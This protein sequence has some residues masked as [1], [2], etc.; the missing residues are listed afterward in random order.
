MKM[1]M[2]SIIGLIAIMAFSLTSCGE[3]PIDLSRGLGVVPIV[4]DINPAVFDGLNKT[5]TFIK[6]TVDM[7]EGAGVNAAAVVVSFN[8]DQARAEVAN[9]TSFPTDITIT[10][11]D[12]ATGLGKTLD[13]ID[14]GDVINV[15]LV[16][17]KGGKTFYSEASFNAAVVCAYNPVT[18]TGNFTAVSAGWAVNGPVTI[19]VD[20]TDDYKVFVSGLPELDG[21]VQDVGPLEMNINPLN[22]SVTA[23]R[24]VLGSVFFIYSNVA[25]QGSGIV[26]TC[27]GTYEMTF[28]ITVDQGSF[29]SYNFTFT[30]N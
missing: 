3:D 2:Y 10:L 6:F 25:Y 20:P 13:D 4:T 19:T 27:N 21:M 26:D 9:V 14:L 22:F 28:T 17:T 8:G 23:P 18:V 11:S 30:K 7:P 16:T 5:T 12:V 29:G 15:E 24:T 1:K